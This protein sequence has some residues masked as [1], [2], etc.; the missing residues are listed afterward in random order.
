M[1]ALFVKREV[2]E[3]TERDGEKPLDAVFREIEEETGITR[4]ALKLVAQYP[5]PLAYE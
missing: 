2:R 4:D 3:S 5:D 1:S